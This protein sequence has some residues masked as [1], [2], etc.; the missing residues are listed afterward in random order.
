MR[1]R[2]QRRA[3]TKQPRPTTSPVLTS[4]PSPGLTPLQLGQL[5]QCTSNSKDTTGCAGTQT[6]HHALDL[7]TVFKENY[8]SLRSLNPK[9]F[10]EGLVKCEDKRFVAKIVSDV[11]QGVRIGYSGPQE[12]RACVNWPSAQ[13]FDAEV[14]ASIEKDVSL[15]R[16]L[17]PFPC[18]PCADF[19]ASQLGAFQKCSGSSKVRVVHDLS[20]PRGRSINDFIDQD[21]CS[22]QYLSMDSVVSAVKKRGKNALLAKADLSD[23]YHH[24]LVHPDDWNLLG[25]VYICENGNIGYY[26]STVLPFGLSSAPAKFT[27][28]AVASKLIML[29]GGATYIEQYLDDYITMGPPDSQ[30][31]QN[32]LEIMLQTFQKL[33][34]TVNP[35]KVSKEP[36]TVRPQQINH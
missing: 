29:Y 25:S 28:I 8:V 19:V 36:A 26:V 18:P 10:E 7:L 27:D 21:E 24:V 30:E 35:N 31:C 14:R 1:V 3:Q 13:K 12:S 4:T 22:V 20:F 16:K 6:G 5:K 11:S 32:N 15:G 17:G 34:F 9:A 33:G 23:A 2:A